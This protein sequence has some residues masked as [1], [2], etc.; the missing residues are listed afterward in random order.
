VRRLLDNLDGPAL[1]CGHSYGGCVITEAGTHPAVR[2]L[3]YISA[4]VPDTGESVRDVGRPPDEKTRLSA[5]LDEDGLIRLDPAGVAAVYSGCDPADVEWAAAR[6]R[7][8]R[9]QGFAQPV[10][11]AAWRSVPATYAVCTADRA[12]D[13]ELQRRMA[14]RACPEVIE[15]P[16]GHFPLIS[17]PDVVAGLLTRLSR[18]AGSGGSR[19]A[20]A[21]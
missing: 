16:A 12:I 17:H 19:P 10:T 11:A 9:P 20:A 1:L 6:L 21:S 2:H 15:W 13:P 7:P 5:H 8:Q 4:F 3:V 14:A 18:E